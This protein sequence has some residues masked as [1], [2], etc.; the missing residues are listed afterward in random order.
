MVITIFEKQNIWGQFLAVQAK[1]RTKATK[2]IIIPAGLDGTLWG[3][4]ASWLG[5]PSDS[6]NGTE[7]PSN[8]AAVG[9]SYSDAVLNRVG[10]SMELSEYQQIQKDINYVRVLL[11]E[12]QQSV[13]MVVERS[14]AGEAAVNLCSNCRCYSGEE[15]GSYRV[16]R[17]QETAVEKA[18]VS[19]ASNFP[20]QSPVVV[21]GVERASSTQVDLEK[22]VGSIE[23]ARNMVNLNSIVENILVQGPDSFVAGTVGNVGENLLERE[24]VPKHSEVIN[25]VFVPTPWAFSNPAGHLNPDPGLEACSEHE[26]SSSNHLLG[27]LPVGLIQAS[28]EP[29]F[30]FLAAPVECGASSEGVSEGTG[31]ARRRHR[32]RTAPTSSGDQNSGQLRQLGFTAAS[33]VPASSGWEFLFK[34]WKWSCGRDRNMWE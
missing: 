30:Q 19:L 26:T 34:I 23:E 9:R 31:K 8:L 1:E 2:F 3:N 10:A 13:R 15:S 22:A 25:D 28:D 17:T 27:A 16:D 21:S 11:E 29:V 12:L 32:F 5:L 4:F 7:A 6:G 24:I 33:K 20:L 18:D 14:I